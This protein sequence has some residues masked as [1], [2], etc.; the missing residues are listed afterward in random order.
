MDTITDFSNVNHDSSLPKLFVDPY[1]ALP[2][3]HFA[4]AMMVG[5]S[6]SRSAATASQGRLGPLP[7]VGLLVVVVTANH[8]WIDAARG[9]V[10][11]ATVSALKW[12]SRLLARARPDCLVVAA[13]R[14]PSEAIARLEAFFFFFFFYLSTI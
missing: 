1:A 4:F 7:A 11:V 13:P 2:S 12:P 10:V 9:G 14:R 3:M 8:F 6:A 5:I